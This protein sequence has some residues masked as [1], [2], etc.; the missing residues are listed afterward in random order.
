[1][2]VPPFRTAFPSMLVLLHLILFL[3]PLALQL[4]YTCG[5]TNGAPTNSPK[6][7]YAPMIDRLITRRLGSGRY[8]FEGG[9]RP[10][11]GNSGACRILQELAADGDAQGDRTGNDKATSSRRRGGEFRHQSRR[12][13]LHR[14]LYK[15]LRSLTAKREA[16]RGTALRSSLFFMC[17]GRLV[18]DPLRP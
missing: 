11:G 17:E 10:A 18:R 14:G 6:T 8:R 3:V 15:I 1:M 16:K 2:V 12:G 5:T 4:L 13:R 9:A 7:H